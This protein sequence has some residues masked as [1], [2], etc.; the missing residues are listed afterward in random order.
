MFNSLGTLEELVLGS[1]AGG[2]SMGC[3]GGEY[4]YVLYPESAA[5]VS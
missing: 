5:L 1:A 3:K 4:L 2:A